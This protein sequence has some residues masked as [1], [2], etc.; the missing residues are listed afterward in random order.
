MS[1]PSGSRDWAVLSVFIAVPVVA[2]L[3]PIVARL[4][5]IVA[6]FVDVIREVKLDVIHASEGDRD[7]GTGNKHHEEHIGA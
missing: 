7:G 5:S 4:V 6:C 3:V 2:C 1:E